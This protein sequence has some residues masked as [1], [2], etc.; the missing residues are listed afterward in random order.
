MI[1]AFSDLL[2]FRPQFELAQLPGANIARYNFNTLHRCSIGN[3]LKNTFPLEFIHTFW[4]VYI[5]NFK[6]PTRVF[7]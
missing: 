7:Y 6:C 1:I 5:V 4:S 2:L 3:C